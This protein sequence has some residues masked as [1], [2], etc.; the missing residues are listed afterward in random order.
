M[1]A[2]AQWPSKRRGA[3]LVCDDSQSIRRLLRVNLELEGFDVLEAADGT[4][5]S[6]LLQE[7]TQDRSAGVV[8][9]VLD[10]QM[11]P[12]DG[13]WALRWLRS[14]DETAHIPVVLVSAS[15]PWLDRSP[16]LDV[17]PDAFVAKPFDPDELIQLVV[18]FAEHGRGYDPRGAAALG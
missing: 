6:T 17:E 7:A 18:G 4:Q 12:R 16:G 10:V 15:N 2:A 3:V 5:C 11:R 8:V 14:H 1:A 13:W 9:V